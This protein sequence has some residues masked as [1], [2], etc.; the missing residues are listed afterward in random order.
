[1][2]PGSRSRN[3]KH[4]PSSFFCN[5]FRSSFFVVQTWLKHLYW[6]IKIIK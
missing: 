6:D 2:S 5:I 1:L 4:R 3:P